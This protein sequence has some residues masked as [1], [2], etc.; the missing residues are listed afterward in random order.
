MLAH[1]R[2]ED[3]AVA[4]WNHGGRAGDQGTVA[5]DSSPEAAP[6]HTAL[7]PPVGSATIRMDAAGQ[8]E[9]HPR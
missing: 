7:A 1:I 2:P 8:G 3:V 4:S 9:F 6:A 5:A